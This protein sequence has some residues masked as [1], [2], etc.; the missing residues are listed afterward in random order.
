MGARQS[1]VQ[2]KAAV[3]PRPIPTRVWAQPPHPVPPGNQNWETTGRKPAVAAPA[4]P[5]Q[6][7]PTNPVGPKPA[8]NAGN[9]QTAPVCYRCGQPG[10]ISSNC[11][12]GQGK[13]CAAATHV[14][15][16]GE[17][18]DPP[19]DDPEEEVPLEVPQEE[20]DKQGKP[21][22]E[23]LDYPDNTVEGFGSEQPHYQ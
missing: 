5:A 13:S 6:P 18:D 20:D 23:D 17:E 10:H 2:H 15:D 11:L 22:L 7:K 19:E 16:K 8:P 12:K 4:R 3:P 9:R 14:A 1:E 21:P